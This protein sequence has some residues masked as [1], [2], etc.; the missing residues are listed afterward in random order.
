MQGD[1]K[2]ED[3]KKGLRIGEVNRKRREEIERKR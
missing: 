2:P 1:S 3:Y